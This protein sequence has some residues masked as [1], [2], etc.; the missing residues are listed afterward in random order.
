[1]TEVG[2]AATGGTGEGLG[3]LYVVATPIGNLGDITQ[4][5]LETLRSVRLVAA[6]DTRHTGNLLRHFQIR[7]PLVSYHA[8]NRAK[9]LPE[10]L[11]VLQAGDVAL[12][13]DA[14]TPIV[15]DPGQE[16]VAAAAA[17]GH[18]VV[19][20]PGPS[21]ALAALSVSGLR[22]D[23]FHF[24]GFLPRRTSQRK[25]AIARFLSWPGAVILFEA[26]HRLADALTDLL[27][28]LGDRRVAVCWELTKLYEGV[29]RTTLSRAL[30]HLGATQPRGEYTIVVEGAPETG[31][32]ARGAGGQPEKPVEP[33]SAASLQARFEALVAQLGDR[34]RALAA[35]AAETG[36]PRKVLYAQL[37]AKRPPPGE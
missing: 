4:R 3:K 21:A 31:T 13:S 14:G 34:R 7:V 1:M 5:A 23:T 24:V 36:V 30:E 10:L 27:A 35:L 16:L 37:V 25:A 6:E 33:P 26:P 12:V 18:R 22:A 28:V 19:P 11:A 15:S 32:T 9:R 29:L 17:A 2:D 20:I 8:H